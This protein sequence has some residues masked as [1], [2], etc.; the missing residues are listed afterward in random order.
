MLLNEIL[1]KA[2]LGLHFIAGDPRGCGQFGD[3][4]ALRPTS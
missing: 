3:P 1:E 2:R 4:D